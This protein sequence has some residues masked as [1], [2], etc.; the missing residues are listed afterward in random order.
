MS[1]GTEPE[2]PL[3]RGSETIL[4]VE[5]DDVFRA[6][7][8]RV[9]KEQGYT[10]LEARTGAAALK[11]AERHKGSVQL[12]LTDLMMP[13]LNGR[14]LWLAF[15]Q[16]YPGAKVLFMSG[17]DEIEI[18]RHSILKA[19]TPFLKKPFAADAIARKVREVLDSP[20]PAML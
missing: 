8:S 4:L 20:F 11:T 10:I 9:L 5:D 19:G 3:P 7:A 6:M 17:Y 15:A 12:L 1:E 13:G 16:L 2:S 14:E 18:F